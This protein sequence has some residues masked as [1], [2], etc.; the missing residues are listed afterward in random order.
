MQDRDKITLAVET[1]LAYAR[2]SQRPFEQAAD[3]FLALRSS[4]GW[5]GAEISQVKSL[6]LTGLMHAAS[7]RQSVRQVKP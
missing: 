6:A 1:C 3:F 2:D 5:T 4:A 7:E